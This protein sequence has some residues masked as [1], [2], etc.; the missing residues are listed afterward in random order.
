MMDNDQHTASHAEDEDE[1]DEE[2][3]GDDVVMQPDPAGAP[4]ADNLEI[5]P[6]F[7]L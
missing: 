5:P 3:E 2:E 6:T 4:E 1:E 7:S